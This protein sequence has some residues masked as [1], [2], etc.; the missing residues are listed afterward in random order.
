MSRREASLNRELESLI[1]GA[2]PGAVV[3]A[4]QKGRLKIELCSGKTYPRYDLASLTKIIFTTTFLMNKVSE[5]GLSLEEPLSKDMPWIKS[6][7]LT[8]ER[9]LMH[10]SGLNWW[11][12]FFKAMDLTR[13]REER[14]KSLQAILC[15]QPVRQKSIA[16]YS[17]LDF[18]ILG[19]WMEYLADKPLLDCWTDIQARLSL[20]D[21]EFHVDNVPVHARTDY[22][23]TE[24]CPWR[25]KILQ[26]E[27]HDENCWSLGGVAP[28]AGLFGTL[29]SVSKWALRIRQSLLDE[30]K[31]DG[32]VDSKVLARFAKR[33]FPAD[34]G[35]WGLGFMKPTKGRASCGRYFGPSSFG[36]TGF[37]GTSIWFEPKQDLIVIVLSNRVHPTRENKKFIEVR[38]RIHDLVC[39]E[40]VK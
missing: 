34:V 28:H 37:T 26:G 6:R 13:P 8:A 1:E 27:V 30:K 14:W 5:D 20:S 19:H 4:Y 17:D 32:F 16:V 15:P 36:H 7:S 35:D 10:H 31:A 25:K 39:K 33:A 24:D 23:P 11:E 40:L 3:R 21:L 18:L 22:A 12:P 2:T 38:P 9:C 29:D